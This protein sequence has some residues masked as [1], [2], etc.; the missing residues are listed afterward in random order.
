MMAASLNTAAL[1]RRDRALTQEAVLQ[2]IVGIILKQ[3]RRMNGYGAS[4]SVG[5][6]LGAFLRRISFVALTFQTVTHVVQVGSEL[7]F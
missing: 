5:Q 7:L 4:E 1:A 3:W 2:R 6:I